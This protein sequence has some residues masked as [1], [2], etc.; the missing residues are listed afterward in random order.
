MKISRIL[1]AVALIAA[2]SLINSETASASKLR[3]T[4]NSM[5]EKKEAVTA[6]AVTIHPASVA[7][8]HDL[9]QKGTEKNVDKVVESIEK[10]IGKTLMSCKAFD[11]NQEIFVAANGDARV[12]KCHFDNPETVPLCKELDKHMNSYGYKEYSLDVY[13]D[14]PEAGE[15]PI[16][17]GPICITGTIGDA[18]YTYYFKDNTLI[19][20]ITGDTKSDNIK[21]NDFL[22]KMYKIFWDYQ[23]I[24]LDP[25]SISVT[26]FPYTGEKGTIKTKT[27]LTACLGKD[28]N[29]LKKVLGANKYY[30]KEKESLEEF[31]FWF[32]VLEYDETSA[33]LY[34]DNDKVFCFFTTADSFWNIPKDGINVYELVKRTGANINDI[35]VEECLGDLYLG[36]EGDTIIS[37]ELEDHL[38]SIIVSNGIVFPDSSVDVW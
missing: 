9:V 34:S 1:T 12:V 16:N 26:D 21:T 33:L 6:E 38:F 23:N 29:N 27:D 35:Y 18:S 7:K 15:E 25:E 31:P 22:N 24:G 4:I 10:V 20:R 28:Y 30:A 3:N 37:L 5:S 36:S 32:Y 2:L 13:Y 17:D 19:R 11:N 8:P 14:N